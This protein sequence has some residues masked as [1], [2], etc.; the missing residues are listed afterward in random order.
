MID[1]ERGSGEQ[2]PGTGTGGGGS[3]SE[4][5]GRD[6]TTRDGAFTRG[7]RVLTAVAE[8]GEIQAGELAERLG[9]PLS[10]TYRYLKSLREFDL[11]EEHA[12]RYIPGWRLSAWSNADIARGRLLEISQRFLLDLRERTGRT[13][14]LAVRAGQHAVC[15]REVVAAGDQAIA[16]R[17]N[18]ELPLDRGAGQ[19]VLLAHAPPAIIEGVIRRAAD[20]AVDHAKY[21]ARRDQVL[22]EIAEIRRTGFAVSN[23]ELKS[24]AKAVAAPVF[25][26]GEVVC[27]IV[28]AG[29][30]D[31]SGPTGIAFMKRVLAESTRNLTARLESEAGTEAR[32]PTS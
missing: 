6:G 22:G 14:V 2:G 31:F 23:S 25:A 4:P 21:L 8:S 28:L 10:T 15:L 27:S 5:T 12:G 30:K 1:R 7:L 20:P 11:V 16:F 13:V 24:G 3:T 9:L 32:F 19:R 29:V 26:G 17:I 18:E